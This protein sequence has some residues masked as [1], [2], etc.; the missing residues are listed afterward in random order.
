M[1]V[2]CG[3]A[4]IDLLL[5]NLHDRTFNLKFSTLF[6]TITFLFHLIT[7]K[8]KMKNEEHDMVPVFVVEHVTA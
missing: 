8:L 1:F 7:K 2:I 3:E 4:I 5:Y 6:F